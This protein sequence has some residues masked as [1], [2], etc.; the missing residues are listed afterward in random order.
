MK[1]GIKAKI[2]VFIFI[3]TVL[4]AAGG[5]SDVAGRT[6]IHTEP[7]TVLWRE[8]ETEN[9]MQEEQTVETKIDGVNGKAAAALVYSVGTGETLF[10]LNAD[11]KRAP[12]SL[13][14]L[15]T[16]L[17][18]L[19]CCPADRV[20]TVGDEITLIAEGSSLSL[21]NRGQ[22]ITLRDLVYAMLLRS[23]NDAAYTVAANT[24]RIINP[25]AQNTSEAIDAF[26]KRMNS[27]AASLGMSG[28]HFTNPDGWDDGNQYVTA[29]DLLTLA[30]AAREN[31]LMKTAF[32]TAEYDATFVSGESITWKNTNYFLHAGLEY[33]RGDCVGIKTGTTDNAGY[34]L[35]SEMTGGDGLII[36]VLGCENNLSRYDV[37]NILSEYFS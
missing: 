23:G 19:N 34:C 14:K 20:F 29:A 31:V 10:S 35:I 26:V 27:V 18:A 3:I 16:A 8:R 32:S 33:Y 7:E 13:T 37:T 12:A 1:N 9:Q 15:L 4:T 30:K 24:G 11:E 22:Q 6:R 36:I 2:A 25:E 17:T 28:S 21:I 5:C